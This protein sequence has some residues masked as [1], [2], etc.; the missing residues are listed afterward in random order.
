MIIRVEVGG[1]GGDGTD[2][3]PQNKPSPNEPSVERFVSGMCRQGVWRRAE[4][5]VDLWLWTKVF[6]L[7]CYVIFF[8]LAIFVSYYYMIGVFGFTCLWMAAWHKERAARKALLSMI[9]NTNSW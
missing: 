3:R 2:R 8:I 7:V 5:S 1:G 4:R 9:K 6:S